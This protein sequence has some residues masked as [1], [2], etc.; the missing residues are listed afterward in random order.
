ML[1][2]FYMKR[3]SRLKWVNFIKNFKLEQILLKEAEAVIKHLKNYQSNNC[4]ITR[5]TACCLLRGI[6]KYKDCN[7]NI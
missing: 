5:R 3:N 7:D 4:S 6:Y 2:G 1:T